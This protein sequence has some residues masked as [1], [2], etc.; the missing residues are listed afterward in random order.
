MI[1]KENL[2]FC[3][4]ILMLV[5]TGT[6]II[7]GFPSHPQ[8]L[9]GDV[10]EHNTLLTDQFYINNVNKTS[11]EIIENP[12]TQINH[13]IIGTPE[14]KTENGETEISKSDRHQLDSKTEVKTNDT[15][16]DSKESIIK[17]QKEERRKICKTQIDTVLKK[18][19]NQEN[20]EVDTYDHEDFAE[21]ASQNTIDL[22]IEDLISNGCNDSRIDNLDTDQLDQVL[23]LIQDYYIKASNRN[24]LPVQKSGKRTE[25]T[26]NKN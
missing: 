24:N 25:P 9:K 26:T 15:S 5:I 12:P 23:G 19:K 16:Q 20:S 10:V 17:E 14:T 11:Y 6:F 21:S 13:G 3:L 22:Q 18:T 7:Y 1:I 4:I 2:H 8:T